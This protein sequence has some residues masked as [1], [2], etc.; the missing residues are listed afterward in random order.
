M[1]WHKTHACVRN[2]C[3][4]CAALR[5]R[6]LHCILRFS[7]QPVLKI[8]LRFGDHEERHVR[9]LLSAVF[10]A[11]AAPSAWLIDL[12]LYFG[13]I[14]RHQIALALHVG[15][16]EAVNHIARGAMDPNRHADGHMNFVSRFDNLVRFVIGIT[17]FPPPLV[18]IDIDGEAH[19][20]RSCFP[21]RGSY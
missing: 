8:L 2:T 11:L 14:A 17:N 18:P 5:C 10:C 9:M 4:P 19:S 3:C 21:E 6:G 15:R 7:T 13:F 16:P 12:H 1:V 20:L